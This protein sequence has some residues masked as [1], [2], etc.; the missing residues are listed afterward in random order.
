MHSSFNMEQMICTNRRNEYSQ[1][2]PSLSILILRDHE[3]DLDG[4]QLELLSASSFSINFHM[5]MTN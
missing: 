1:V 5:V 2:N 3:G 4:T